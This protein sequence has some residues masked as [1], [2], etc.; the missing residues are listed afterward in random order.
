MNN[1][2]EHYQT[3]YVKNYRTHCM[4]YGKLCYTT[5]ADADI[6]KAICEYDFP[7]DYCG[8]YK[9]DTCGHYHLTSTKPKK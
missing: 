1:L 6:A 9:C 7:K 5:K 3:T 8:I 2:T 4:K